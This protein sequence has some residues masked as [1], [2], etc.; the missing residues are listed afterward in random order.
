MEAQQVL[1]LHV[2]FEEVDNVQLASMLPDQKF[3]ST[4]F[5]TDLRYTGSC[6]SGQAKD[7]LLVLLNK[8]LLLYKHHNL[9]P[10][11]EQWGTF[12]LQNTA[13]MLLTC[14]NDD[15]F[16]DSMKG[17][18][19]EALPKLNLVQSSIEHAEVAVQ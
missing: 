2:E 9:H 6:L 18:Q 3:H 16:L 10:Y 5:S 19:R 17:L 15:K 1:E 8:V 14:T 4:Y 12:E 7:L 13:D 11:M